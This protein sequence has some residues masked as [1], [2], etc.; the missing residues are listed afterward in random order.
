MNP[1]AEACGD[2]GCGDTP[3]PAY[4]RVRSLSGHFNPM[5]SMKTTPAL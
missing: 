2:N 1:A 3:R 5:R 4:P